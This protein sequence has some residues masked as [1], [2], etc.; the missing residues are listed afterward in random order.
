MKLVVQSFKDAAGA[1]IARIPKEVA[2]L[3][4]A[5]KI[6]LLAGNIRLK[7]GRGKN[8]R[9][10]HENALQGTKPCVMLP[11]LTFSTNDAESAR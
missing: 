1:N 7:A 6:V 10:G 8:S 2:W 4:G 9:D 11:Q 5:W 3:S